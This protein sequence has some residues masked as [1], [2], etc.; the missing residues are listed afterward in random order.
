MKLLNLEAH[1]VIY[2]MLILLGQ[3][4]RLQKRSEGEL[5]EL[6][7]HLHLREVEVELV[8]AIDLA[9]ILVNLVHICRFGVLI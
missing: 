2:V 5:M 6:L 8:S 1:S 7:L 3:L 9:R 4:I